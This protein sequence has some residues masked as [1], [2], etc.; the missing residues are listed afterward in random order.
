MIYVSDISF[1]F[2]AIAWGALIALFINHTNLRENEFKKWMIILLV[3]SIGLT[4]IT[5]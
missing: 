4:I 5:Y 2:F 1:V 3:L